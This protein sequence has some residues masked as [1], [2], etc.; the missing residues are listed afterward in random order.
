MGDLFAVADEAAAFIVDLRSDPKRAPEG[1]PWRVPV[2]FR[3]SE[4]W[5]TSVNEKLAGMCLGQSAL[6]TAYN[7]DVMA[8]RL[9]RETIEVNATTRADAINAAAAVVLD[10][11]DRGLVP[12]W[13]VRLGDAI[14]RSTG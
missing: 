12:N 7:R 2:T 10:A 13:P 5:H 9:F 6:Q 11:V 3:P 1:V 4:N 14:P 8:P